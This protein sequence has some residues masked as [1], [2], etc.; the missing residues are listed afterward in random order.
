MDKRNLI[1][2]INSI[3]IIIHNILYIKFITYDGNVDYAYYF[4]WIPSLLLICQTIYFTFVIDEN[5]LYKSY[6]GICLAIGYFFCMLGDIS[7]IFPYEIAYLFGMILFIPVHLIIGASR[8]C[9]ID[10]HRENNN[11]VA[12]ISGVLVVTIIQFCYVPYLISLLLQKKD[13]NVEM[14]IIAIVVYSCFINFSVSVQYIYLV[15]Y[16][17]KLALASFVGMFLFAVSDSFLIYNDMH[18][19]ETWLGIVCLLLYWSGLNILGWSI[20]H[21]KNWIESYIQYD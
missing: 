9:S 5:E 2:M 15:I 7:L 13:I 8:L 4:K 10:Y 18:Y 1:L 20:Y 11:T 19:Q 21:K 16:Q 12:V 17:N 6:Y 14:M 3:I